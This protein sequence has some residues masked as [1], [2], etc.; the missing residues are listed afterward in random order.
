MFKFWSLFYVFC[1]RR[2]SFMRHS[3]R[4]HTVFHLCNVSFRILAH[5]YCCIL[6]TW[7]I[8]TV[9]YSVADPD[10]FYTDPVPAFHF[11][12]D[13]DPTFHFDLS[14]WSG[15]GSDF[16]LW[17][18]SGSDYLIGIGILTVSKRGNVRK[19]VRYFLF[20]FTW[21]LLSVGQLG[22]NQQLIWLCSLV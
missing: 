8:W 19:T 20:I 12:T 10:R 21:F 2:Q 9:S 3:Q 13:P 14:I 15:S 22:P 17:S 5:M 4:M 7:W 18:G 16:S 11:E 6:H 1:E